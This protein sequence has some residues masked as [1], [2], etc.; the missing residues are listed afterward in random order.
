MNGVRTAQLF[1]RVDAIEHAWC[2]RLNRGC[3]RPA[4]RDIFSAISKLG[5]PKGKHG[6]IARVK[7]EDAGTE[8]WIILLKASVNDDEPLP[9]P[10]SAGDSAESSAADDEDDAEPVPTRLA[11]D[12]AES[13]L[14]R[15]VA[16]GSEALS[17][18]P[19]GGVTTG[20]S[21]ESSR[22]PG[23]VSPWAGRAAAS[24]AGDSA[25]SSLAGGSA[26]RARWVAA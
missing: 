24:R 16:S 6:A 17:T 11:R 26:S 23:A 2:L 22:P 18:A 15:T 20:A 5:D 21:A 13:W 3:S 7:Y 14:P 10:I 1:R 9:T 12:S 25:E 4:V 19:L 8:S